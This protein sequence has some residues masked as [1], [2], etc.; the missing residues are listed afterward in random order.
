MSKGIFTDKTHRPSTREIHRAIHPREAGWRE[1]LK[2]IRG[3]FS[4]KEELKFYGKNFG[5]ALR[6]TKAGKA[7]L[8]LYPAE[9]GFT[10]QIILSNADAEKACTLPIGA[11]IRKTIAQAH[12]YPEGRWLFIPVKTRQDFRDVRA[13]VVLKGDPGQTRKKTG[14]DP[15]NL[16]KSANRR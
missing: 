11:R 8:S 16:N 12:P 2:F 5:W 14:Q 4:C 10:A 1:F 3:S 15:D 13:L 7:L 6:F 9:G